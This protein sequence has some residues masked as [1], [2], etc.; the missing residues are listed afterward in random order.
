MNEHKSV[1]FLN[2]LLTM[3]IKFKK[4]IFRIKTYKNI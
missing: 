4:N 3:A 1:D 2:E